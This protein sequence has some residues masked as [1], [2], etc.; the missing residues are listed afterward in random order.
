MRYLVVLALLTSGCVTLATAENGCAGTYADL[1]RYYV[2]LEARCQS[3]PAVPDTDR[4]LCAA[5]ARQAYRDDVQQREQQRVRDQSEAFTRGQRS[6]CGRATG[7]RVPC[8][9]E[10]PVPAQERREECSWTWAWVE[11]DY[12]YVY[13]CRD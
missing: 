3:S 5:Q 13:I 1:C 6:V 2:A 11:G 9:G 7:G 8:P 4:E 12:R 10:R